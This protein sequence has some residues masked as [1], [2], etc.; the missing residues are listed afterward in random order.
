M[1]RPIDYIKIIGDSYDNIESLICTVRYQHCDAIQSRYVGSPSTILHCTYQITIFLLV[2]LHHH[3]Q[4]QHPPASLLN[5]K[6]PDQFMCSLCCWTP[7]ATYAMI[8]QTVRIHAFL[9]NIQLFH[10]PFLLLALKVTEMSS[11]YIFYT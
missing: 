8:L 3:D 9:I 5:A 10:S 7:C 6:P 1:N 4:H 2:T 11:N